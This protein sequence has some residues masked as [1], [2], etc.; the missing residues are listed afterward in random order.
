LLLTPLPARA[1]RASTLYTQGQDAEA[2]QDY[3]AAYLSYAQAHELKPKDLRYRAAAIRMRLL[4]SE[5]HVRGGQKLRES[6]HLSDAF[7]EFQRAALIDPASFIAQQ[8]IRRTR[9]MIEAAEAFKSHGTPSGEESQ[10]QKRIQ[11]MLG[12]VELAPISRS[13]ISLRMTENSKIVYETLGKLAGINVIFDAEYSPRPVQI[14]L[15]NVSLEDALQVLALQSSTFWRPVTANT[16]FV[17]LD[18]PLKRKELE[19][20]VIRT[21][22]LSNM[23]QASD[24]QD[25]ATTLRT[26]LD[27]TRITPIPGESAI[28]VRGSPDQIEVAEKLVRDLDKPRPEVVVEVAIL[29]ITRDQVHNLGFLP[30]TSASVV[31]QDSKSSSSGSISLNKLANLNATDFQVTLSKA[32]LNLLFSDSQTKLIQNPQIRAKDGQKA[33]L[34]IGERVPVATGSFTSGT[35]STSALV[36]TQFQYLDV[37]VNIDITPKV[38]ADGAVTLKLAIEVSAVDSTT[39]IGGIAEPVIGQRKIE[40][41]IQLKEGEANLL[42]GILEELTSKTVSGYPGLSKVPV[43]KYLFSSHDTENRQNEIVF[44]LVPHIV[45]DHEVTDINLKAIDVGSANGIKIRHSEE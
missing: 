45:R 31:L 28:V 39:T 30:P 43:V 25:V 12:P 40:H 14:E 44:A 1:D 29:Q 13:R 16:I 32:E 6:G 18:T 38:L 22:Y 19:Q 20:S 27:L 5:A 4:A 26:V 7:L 37:G 8:E 2:R 42:G 21:F 17:A 41:E 15:T 11:S 9:V 23:S 34:K 36:N 24:F 3:A 10:N 33:S 35:T